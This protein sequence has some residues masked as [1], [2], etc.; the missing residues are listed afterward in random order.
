MV[1]FIIFQTVLVSFIAATVARI[2]KFNSAQVWGS[3]YFVHTL[4]Y[5]VKM[6]YQKNNKEIWFCL[7]F[8][9]C[10]FHQRELYECD[11]GGELCAAVVLS[12]LSAPWTLSQPEHL[13]LRL[14]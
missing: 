14:P 9:G 12:W 4:L 3:H 13:S 6:L 1:C 11:V 8:T 7:C 5:P 2:V 10:S